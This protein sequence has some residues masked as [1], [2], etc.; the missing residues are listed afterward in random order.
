MPKGTS[1]N[2]DSLNGLFHG[3][4]LNPQT[5]AAAYSDVL[6]PVS[7]GY[8]NEM[9]SHSG[10]G[11]ANHDIFRMRARYHEYGDIEYI[12]YIAR[13]NGL[14]Q[15][16]V[17]KENTTYKPITNGCDKVNNKLTEAA[18]RKIEKAVGLEKIL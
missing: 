8:G 9:A 6:V 15:K 17:P 12:K 2:T 18:A 1:L 13:E 16:L 5:M 10:F 4:N 14:D 7:K 3:T 11:G